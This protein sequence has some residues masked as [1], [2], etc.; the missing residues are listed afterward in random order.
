MSDTRKIR[1]TM[2]PW[3]EVEVSE[4]EYTDLERQGLILPDKAKPD[5]ETKAKGET[6]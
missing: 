2:E 6:R 1:T 5:T 4:Q 3:R